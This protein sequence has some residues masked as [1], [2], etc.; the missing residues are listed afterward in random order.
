MSHELVRS[1][2]RRIPRGCGCFGVAGLASWF[3]LGAYDVGYA[4]GVAEGAHGFAVVASV[5]VEGL[6]IVQKAP[7]VDSFDAGLE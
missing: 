6:D 2:V 3:F 4:G 7:S 1:T 5:E